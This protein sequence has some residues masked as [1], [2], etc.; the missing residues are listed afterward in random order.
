MAGPT[1]IAM[2]STEPEHPA[3]ADPIRIAKTM[4]AITGA[5]EVAEEATE[6][7]AIPVIPEDTKTATD[8]HPA[9]MR[10]IMI[11][12][13][14]T[15]NMVA[16]TITGTA[17]MEVR[18]MVMEEVMAET[19]QEEITAAAETMTMTAMKTITTGDMAEAITT[20]TMK[21]DITEVAGTGEETVTMVVAGR[22]MT[23]KTET[24]SNELGN[25]YV[26]PGT[27]GQTV[28][29][30]T[31]ITTPTETTDTMTMEMAFLNGQAG[32]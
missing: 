28:M 6:E 12:T 19:M 27:A 26:I 8:I 31:A 24:F 1:G 23:A 16:G 22:T 29:I 9:T 7:A 4:T 15:N 10:D 20:W 17:T 5:M 11:T 18:A 30:T 14:G 32:K 2:I 21:T 3:H 25:G 13:I